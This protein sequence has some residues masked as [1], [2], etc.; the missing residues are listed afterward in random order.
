MSGPEEDRFDEF[1]WIEQ[2]LKPLA[3]GAAEALGLAD[4]AAVV[5]G[6]P[7]FDLIISKDA[8]V[9]GVHFLPDDPPDLVARK[10]LRVNLSDLAAKGAEPYGYFLAVAWPGGATRAARRAFAEGLKIDQAEYGLRLM[11]GDTVWCWSA[12]PSAMAGWVCGR[13]KAVWPGQQLPTWL[14][15]PIDIACRSP[16][17]ALAPRCGHRL[18]RRRTSPMA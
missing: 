18:T 7:G 9:E 3:E 1:D 10:L 6:R 8:I 16:A 2:D 12:G 14:G 17:L 15:S 13:R 11:G 5:P 4:D